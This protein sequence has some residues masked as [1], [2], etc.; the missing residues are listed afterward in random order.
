MEHREYR[1][2][3]SG[4]RIEV[5]NI[6]QLPDLPTGCESVSL[7]I[8]L[9]YLGC[10]TDKY[11]IVRKYLPKQE[12]YYVGKELHGADFRTTFAGDPEDENSFGCYA[13]CIAST[14]NTCLRDKGFHAEA[15]DLTG[16]DFETLLSDYIDKGIP[17]PVWITNY[18]LAESY[19]SDS[20][21]TPEG[22]LLTWRSP[23][24]CVVLTGYDRTENLVYVSDPIYGN[25]EYDLDLFVKRFN[26]MGKQAVYI[27]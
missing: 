5:K 26:E 20:W 21:K 7:T 3:R 17:L 10:H 22:E 2:T 24:H 19:L 27:Y 18:G 15:H 23:E 12:F 25:T 11:E 9:N 4:T 14:A 13:P 6:L 16:T 1:K 8:T